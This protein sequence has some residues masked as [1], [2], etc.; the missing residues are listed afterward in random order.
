MKHEDAF[1][2][3]PDLLDDRDDAA[4]LRHVRDC[5]DCQRQLFLLNRIDRA[6]RGNAPTATRRRPTRFRVSAAVFA[7]AAAAA[8]VAAFLPSSARTHPYMLRASSGA[9]LAQATMKHADA[10]NVALV[11]LTHSLPVASG[12]M[13]ILWASDRQTRMQAGRFMADEQGRAHVRFNLP[14]NHH[15]TRFWITRPNPAPTMIASTV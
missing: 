1:R 13:F 11:L 15:W 2:K 6:L 5:A 4:L 3:L 7:A 14:A 12:H 9:I 10:R 8:V